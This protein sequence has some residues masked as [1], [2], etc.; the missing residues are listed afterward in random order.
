MYVFKFE[1]KGDMLTKKLANYKMKNKKKLLRNL[2]LF[3]ILILLTFFVIFKDQNPIQILKALVKAQKGYIIVAIGFMCFYLICEAINIGR[4]LKALGEKSN[5]LQNIKY[6]LIGFF[7]SSITP[8]ASGGQ[9]MQI[10]YM[11]KDKITVANSTL[12]LLINLTCMQIVTISLA[13]VSFIFNYQYMNKLLIG[14]FIIGIF[15]NASALT[16]LLIS[17]LSKRATNWLI[18]MVIKILRFFKIKNIESKKEKIENELSKYQTSS[19]Y[20]KNNKIV[21]LKTLLI[22]YIQ[23]LAYYSI[24]YWVYRSFGLSQYNIFEIT[25]MQSVLF[26]TVSGIPSPGAVGVSEGGFLAI[27]KNIYPEKMINGAMLLNRGVSFY[28]FVI[29]SAVVVIVS[30]IKDKKELKQEE[31]NELQ[32]EKEEL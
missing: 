1:N 15:L 31:N 8:A 3:L 29:I 14:F 27:Y 20:I 10:Y 16:L 2:V 6:S 5:F 22:S 26:A 11:H 28:L 4:T 23:F 17:I 18:N 7:F 19:T 32:E 13:L 9:P 25:S 24:S 12:A 21:I 30:S